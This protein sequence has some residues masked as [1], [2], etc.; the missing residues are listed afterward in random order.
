M[1]FVRD[2]LLFTSLAVMGAHVARGSL[3]RPNTL[4]DSSDHAIRT[5]LF[6]NGVIVFGGPR[7]YRLDEFLSRL[8][9]DRFCDREQRGART[10]EDAADGEVI[11]SIPG[12][13]VDAKDDEGLD[14]LLLPA[15][16]ERGQE[17]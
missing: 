13:T 10:Q 14:V 17:L 8:V 4:G 15:E 5:A 16:L 2:G 11:F 12:K 6:A 3:E 7:E 1:R 9:A